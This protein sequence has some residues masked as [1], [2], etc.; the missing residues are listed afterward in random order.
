MKEQLNFYADLPLNILNEL[1]EIY[2]RSTSD[3]EFFLQNTEPYHG[4]GEWAWEKKNGKN[5]FKNVLRE[6]YKISSKD[7]NAL[8]RAIGKNTKII[9]LNQ[10][11][12]AKGKEYR[13][14]HFSKNTIKTGRPRIYVR[15][16]K[17]YLTK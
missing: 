7:V 2:P 11:V 16:L 13:Q 3:I 5:Y 14:I 10:S 8:K 17:I 15:P 4:L 1:N 9:F 6:K 12:W